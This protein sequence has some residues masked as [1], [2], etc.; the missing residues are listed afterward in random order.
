[1]SRPWS[2]RC[3]LALAIAAA[4]LA[5]VPPKPG[6]QLV[7]LDGSAVPF[8]SL[9]IAAGKLSGEDVPADLALDDL[10]RIEVAPQTAVATPTV[11]LEL[12]GGGRLLAKDVTLGDDKC[13]AQ[14]S[15]AEPLALPID[16][17]R[18]IRLDPATA[19]PD[20]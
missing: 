11:I 20:F 17:V 8:R 2:H 10:R 9:E 15:A 13:R 6:P 1:M 19:S 18:A 12:R 7:L 14:W 4:A 5:Q 3:F 16:I